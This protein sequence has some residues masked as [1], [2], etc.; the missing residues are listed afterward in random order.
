[1]PKMKTHSGAKKRFNISKG[2][3]IKRAKAYKSHI[4]SKKSAKRKM[5]LRHA[6]LVSEADYQKVKKLI[7]YK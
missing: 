1:M 7:P 3:K 6:G 5:N 2:G 4:L